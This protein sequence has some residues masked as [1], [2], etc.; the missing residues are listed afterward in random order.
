MPVPEDEPEDDEEAVDAIQPKR[1]GDN[2]VEVGAGTADID[3][4]KPVRVTRSV[5]ADAGAS[6]SASESSIS[7]NRGRKPKNLVL[8]LPRDFLQNEFYRDV[9]TNLWDAIVMKGKKEE[10]VDGIDATLNAA[11]KL[12]DRIRKYIVESPGSASDQ[13]SEGRIKLLMETQWASSIDMTLFIHCALKANHVKLVLKTWCRKVADFSGE[14][15]PAGLSSENIDAL[16]GILK[17]IDG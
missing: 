5:K 8:N 2:V 11:A 14:S 1:D 13:T 6:K 17:K 10:G 12:S 15:C 7:S 3:Q 4:Q 9:R 16:C